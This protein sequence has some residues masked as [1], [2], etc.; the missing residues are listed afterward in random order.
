M[1]L[2]KLSESVKEKN[3]EYTDVLELVGD[4]GFADAGALGEDWV[5]SAG[6]TNFEDAPFCVDKVARSRTKVV[7]GASAVEIFDKMK[8]CATSQSDVKH[9][10]MDNYEASFCLT[11]RKEGDKIIIDGAFWDEDGYMPNKNRNYDPDSY[12]ELPTSRVGSNETT[13]SK[14][15]ADK[16]KKACGDAVPE[17]TIRVV[18]GGH[19]HPQTMEMGQINN[20][21]SR[22]DIVLAVE[23]AGEHYE[24][25]DKTCMFL[26]AIVTA[27][28]DLNIFGIDEK[29]EFVIFDKVQTPA[30]KQIAAYTEGNYPLSS[31]PNGYSPN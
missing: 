21:P 3:L 11:G 23:E 16:M 30:G 2:K 29:G 27:D 18:V 28:G 22:T 9:I 5:K 13:A 15:F 4:K 14:G 24:Q 8:K 12:Y 6:G 1:D 19:T 20:Y 31:G 17:G 10:K 26:N 25:G 7:L